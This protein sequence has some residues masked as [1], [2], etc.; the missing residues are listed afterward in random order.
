MT[1]TRRQAVLASGAVL[2]AS[3]VIGRGFAAQRARP[4]TIGALTISWG[5]TPAIAG[6][7]DGLKALGY[8][9]DYD[10]VIG[11]RFTQGNAAELPAA[12][13]SLVQS[14]VDI[15]VT[16]SGGNATTAAQSATQQIPIVFLGE[17]DPVGRK[18]ISSLARPG[19][20]ITG[21]SN[22]ETELAPKKMEIFQELVPSL[23][24]IVVV[25]DST[26]AEAVARLT[27]D[28]EAARRLG[29]AILEKPVRNEDEARAAINGVKKSATDGFFT[30]RIISLNIP[31]LTLEHAAQQSIP[32]MFD[33]G[34]FV[35]RGAL[36]SYSA[37][38]YELGRQ[39][40]RLVGKIM[41]GAKPADIPV[42]QPT[43]FELAINLKTAKAL[44]IKVPNSILLRADKVIE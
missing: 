38:T 24:R 1:V 15:I 31:G 33:E 8:R 25:Y 42:E 40:A 6:L 14:G 27:L 13:R 2:A 7:R 23:K 32:T 11:V 19:G 29:L 9:E 20:N 34:F 41:K 43:K 4:F 39:A 37:N 44:G 10:F 36:A 17:S 16:S 12:A 26:N 18:L 5:P 30:S 35:E 22:L 21:V 28:R 3:G